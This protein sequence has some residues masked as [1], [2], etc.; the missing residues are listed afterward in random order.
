MKSD[1]CKSQKWQ[2]SAD[3]GIMYRASLKIAML[4]VAFFETGIWQSQNKR[5]SAT[6]Y[7]IR[8][9]GDCIRSVLNAHFT[10]DQ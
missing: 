1:S 6:C 3:I 8:N 2:I 5:R 10:T 9:K 7:L 4:I